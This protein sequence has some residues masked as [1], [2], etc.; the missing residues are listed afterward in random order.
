MTNTRGTEIFL[1]AAVRD[2]ALF[3]RDGKLCVRVARLRNR[4]KE[5]FFENLDPRQASVFVDLVNRGIVIAP[6]NELPA[7]LVDDLS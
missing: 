4:K 2:G 6:T 1:L 3:E 5:I 7:Q